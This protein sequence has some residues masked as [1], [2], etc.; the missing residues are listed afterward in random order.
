MIQYTS[1]NTY[2]DVLTV[3]NFPDGGAYLRL[4]ILQIESM[5][6]DDELKMENKGI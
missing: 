2:S 1:Q 5:T 4:I 6:R 3:D